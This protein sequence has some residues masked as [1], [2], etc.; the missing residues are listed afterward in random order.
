M[1]TEDEIKELIEYTYFGYR[2]ETVNGVLGYKLSNKNNEENYIFLPAAGYRGD[3][4]IRYPGNYGRYWGSTLHEDFPD[5]AIILTF[6]AGG[7]IPSFPNFS[8]WSRC[9][10]LSIRPVLSDK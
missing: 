3:E 6:E 10:G 4:Y 1:P 8:S 7:W 9:D 2:P 5:N